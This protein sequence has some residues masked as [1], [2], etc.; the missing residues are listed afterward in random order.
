MEKRFT[1][2]LIIVFGFISIS[3][4]SQT[5]RN[6][7]TFSELSSAVTLASSSVVDTINFLGNITATAGITINKNIFI[8]GN[9]FS[10]SAPLPG[11]SA[12]GAL[13]NTSINYRLF[14]VSGPIDLRI[15]GLTMIGGYF[16]NQ[17]AVM[18]IPSG[19]RVRIKNSKITQSRASAGGG[20]HNQGN[21]AMENCLFHRNAA[22]YGGGLLNTGNGTVAYL[23][24]VSMVE[25][26][27]L[28]SSGGGGAAENGWGSK[29]YF[30][31]STLA[32]NQSTEIGGAINNPGGT[33]YFVNSTATGN[34]AFGPWIASGGAFGNN[35]GQIFLINSLMAYNYSRNGGTA[36]N[37][38]S[39]V[40]DDFKPYSGSGGIRS[41]YSIY[42][43]PLPSGLGLNLNN[44]KY[45]G[46]DDG[47][48]NSIFSGG[49][50]S[51]ITNDQGYEIGVPIFRPFL[52]ETNGAIVS[53]LKFGS[54]ALEAMNRGTRT[55][56][57]LPDGST[58]EVSCNGFDASKFTRNGSATIQ[59][60]V[61]TLTLARS[62]QS[63][64]VWQNDKLDLDAD[65][66]IDADVYLGTIDASGADG[67]AFVLQ[68][69]SVNAGSS[70]GGLG[71]AGISPSIA[72]EYDTWQNAAD[73]T[74]QDH[75]ALMLNGNTGNHNQIPSAPLVALGNI[76]DGKWHKVKISWVAATKKFTHYFDDRLI[77][78]ITYDI[79]ANVFSNNRYV[80][81]GFTGATGGAVNEQRVR[82]N[83]MCLVTESTGFN[84]IIAYYDGYN[85]T[86]L[87]GT[88]S[89]GQEVLNDQ[90]G[91]NRPD[92]PARGA[93]EGIIAGLVSIK[94]VNEPANAGSPPGGTFRG[95]SIY[96]D[97]YPLGTKVSLVASPNTS[98]FQ[99]AKW[100][101]L[102]G[103]PES[104]SLSARTSFSTATDT[105]KVN[106]FEITL[107]QNTIVYPSFEDCGCGCNPTD[108]GQIGSNQIMD[109]NTQSAPLESIESAEILAGETIE[110]K[111][112]YS[113]TSAFEGFID[114]P[115]TDSTNY[116]PG[117]LTENIWFRRLAKN[118]CKSDWDISVSSNVIEIVVNKVF[119]LTISCL[120]NA[121]IP[122]GDDCEAVIKSDFVTNPVFTGQ[123]IYMDATT[124][125]SSLPFGSIDTVG[126]FFGEGV[127]MYGLYS[128]TPDSKGMHQL[129]C[130]GT[131]TSTDVDVPTLVGDTINVLDDPNTVVNESIFQ[132][133]G[134]VREMDFLTWR[135][136]LGFDDAYFRPGLYSCWQS[137][138]HAG[139]DF[140]WPNNGVRTYETIRIKPAFNGYLTL[141]G[142]SKLNSNEFAN[143]AN[144]DPVISVYADDFDPENPCQNMIAF[145][146]SGFIPNPLAGLGFTMGG[147]NG[148]LSGAQQSLSNVFAPWLLHNNPV[149]RMDVK[150]QEGKEYVVVMTHR[151]FTNEEFAQEGIPFNGS[152]FALYMND[153]TT[154]VDTS[155]CLPVRVNNFDDIISLQTSIK[156]NP[157]VINFDSIRNFAFPDLDITDFITPL[158]GG[159]LGTIQVNWAKLGSDPAVSLPDGSTLFELCFTTLKNGES[160]VYLSNSPLSYL[161]IDDSFDEKPFRNDPALITVGSGL[162]ETDRRVTNGL[163]EV[164]FM[165]NDYSDGGSITG[166][167][168]NILSN[169]KDS[170]LYDTS[171][172]F[173][174]FLCF[175]LNQIYIPTGR[176]RYD[177]TY[178]GGTMSTLDRF[179]GGDGNV[180]YEPEDVGKLATKWRLLGQGLLGKSGRDTSFVDVNNLYFG[181]G[182]KEAAREFARSI[183]LDYG[184][185]PL[186]I[187]NCNGF[188]VRIIDDYEQYGD[189]GIDQG[190]FAAQ[191]DGLNVYGMITRTYIIQ[192]YSFRGNTDTAQIQMI[193]R[194]PNLGDL[195]LPHYTV[196]LE[197]DQ[198]GE[199]VH[200]LPNG[201]PSPASTGYPFIPTLTG[202]VDLT[203]DN[204]VCNLSAGYRDV[205][206][207]TDCSGNVSFRREWTIYDWCRPG[208]TVIYNQLIKVGDYTAPELDVTSASIQTSYSG[209]NCIGQAIISRGNATDLCGFHK[210]DL[211]VYWIRDGF[212]ANQPIIIDSVI[213]EE[214]VNLNGNEQI[215]YAAQNLSSSNATNNG[216]F[217]SPTTNSGVSASVDAK[218]SLTVSNLKDGD[219]VAV[220]IAKDV[221]GN[222]FA[223]LDS[224]QISDNIAPT[225]I[226]D[227]IRT[228]TLTNFE[229]GGPSASVSQRGEAYL[230]AE[231]LN[232]G[233][234]DNC[235]EV[236]LEVR[237]M[238]SVGMSVWSDKVGFTCED[239]GDSVLV[240]MKSTAGN[241][242]TICW[243]R[244]SVVDK[245][246][247]KCRDIGTINLMCSD[248][249]SGDL[250]STSLIWDA[251]FR[252][253]ITTNKVSLNQLCNVDFDSNIF[254]ESNIDQCGYGWVNRYYRVFRNIDGKEFA[255]TCRMSIVFSEDHDYWVT[256][257][258]DETSVCSSLNEEKVKFHE[259]GC[260]LI[261]ISKHDEKFEA[262]ANECYKIFRTFRVI[263]WCE[264]DGA[265]FAYKV[266]RRDWNNDGKAGDATTL[267]VKYR[268]GVRH[269]FWDFQDNVLAGDVVNRADRRDTIERVGQQ[270]AEGET[271]Y[272]ESAAPLN[273]SSITSALIANGTVKNVRLYNGSTPLNLHALNGVN[274]TPQGFFEYTQHLQ[275]YDNVAPEI[276]LITT[277]LIF[278]SYSND[279]SKGCPGF[280][281]ISAAITDDCTVSLGDLVLSD[282]LLDSGNDGV[283]SITYINDKF[284][285]SSY[286]GT[287]LYQ[288]TFVSGI[289]NIT[290]QGL[291]TGHHKFKLV[292]TDGCGNK[293]ELDIHFEVKDVKGPAPVCIEGFAVELM[294][295]SS[296]SAGVATVNAVD[297]LVNNPIDDCN[298]DSGVYLITRIRNDNGSNKTPGQILSTPSSQTSI[299]LSCDDRALNQPIQVAVIATDGVG[300][301]D[302]C[303]TTI[304]VQDNVTPCA[305]GAAVSGLVTT[306]GFA[307]IPDV[308]VSVSLSGHV[309]EMGLKMT[310]NDGNYK[311]GGL[312]EGMD[313]SISSTKSDV[314][315]NG[316]STFDIILITKHLLGEQLLNSPYKLI[317]ADVNNSKSI[318]TLDIIHLRKILLG[319]DSQFPNNKVWRFI[320]ADFVFPNPSNPWQTIFPELLNINNL[321]GE[322]R[323][324][325]I[326]IKTGDV[327]GS[328]ILDVQPR[329]STLFVIHANEAIVK[330]GQEVEVQFDANMIG[331]DGFQ[332]TLD[333]GKF[334]LKDIKDGMIRKDQFGLKFIN[335]GKLL[336]SFD[337]GKLSSG[338]NNLFTLVLSASTPLVVSEQLKVNGQFL[339]GEAYDS[340]GQVNLVDLRF[341][342]IEPLVSGFHL[343]QNMPN[344]FSEQT[345]VRFNLPESGN[346][347]ITFN[348]VTGRVLKVVKGDFSKGLN[349]IN[350]QRT[351]LPSGGVYYYT[352][353]YNGLSVTQKMV[354][355]G[356]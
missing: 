271:V 287:T 305:A 189:C 234:S 45:N 101:Y 136:D 272:W 278:E 171:F 264:Y 68:P 295:T 71:Y 191:T 66:S 187:D 317:A 167:A 176:V 150:V 169:L 122:L 355:I 62:N 208:T 59:G 307:S 223:H 279:K 193:F 312:I 39:Y 128:N 37:P 149:T 215:V 18:Y 241:E 258:G 318:S 53:P 253:S 32:N 17:G 255:D 111:W 29:L 252:D 227:D 231:R 164:Y 80:Y 315:V 174:D 121:V 297:F 291:P 4:H 89:P 183:V 347:T 261:T 356:K 127:W 239:L 254:T 64:S 14:T 222:T 233:S 60:N 288:T 277:D 353:R 163:F 314:A 200:L 188:S 3:L 327:N 61:V 146:E 267:N 152:G 306:E 19:A 210:I 220:W 316:I 15:D 145:G 100:T 141:I 102:E 348:D 116:S 185:M 88:S 82:F 249:P 214:I 123:F 268:Q 1:K 280:V 140:T 339:K 137:T 340:E 321:A 16:N 52:Y 308:Q 204:A 6:V 25:N 323:A 332:M 256:F 36:E 349:Q 263:N 228:I 131:F 161:V 209:E 262:T 329:S 311:V 344:P 173:F 294:P 79:K 28:G 67:I 246:I 34:V 65:F 282:V 84:P 206:E 225:C 70:G 107:L 302:Y 94:V 12:S 168:T 292:V 298:N 76:E 75:T 51:K 245:T 181:R 139:S 103:G 95:G 40:L 194:T 219:Y 165:R 38:T 2:A 235:H 138:N 126:K 41:Y 242:S 201:L 273:R 330:A 286:Q 178:T 230:T 224:F 343:Y 26:R 175:D 310:D 211:K 276:E 251:Y 63:G 236:T 192:D 170:L 341:N 120:S 130:W 203:P 157:L 109:E 293:N 105:V 184:F 46:L 259:G 244:I 324:D 87:S 22:N 119:P 158:E 198:L 48:D 260:D 56:V 313:Y 237:R 216:S 13:N 284:D 342:H 74:P 257:P 57:S 213:V 325:F 30:N 217:V 27:S 274:Y 110:Y 250:S 114:I 290:S 54:F 179:L 91:N 148:T 160:Q 338:D 72:I 43:A 301:K 81:W 303:V 186:A 142:A 156:F 104:S 98:T 20:I 21:L 319:T 97:V 8:K 78:D 49:A 135:G 275:V 133:Y 69:L 354:L 243:T 238:T 124:I 35:G 55:R 143:Q 90:A 232:E 180:V 50:L 334:E 248:L 159:P 7:S 320:P 93:M 197:C 226:M 337:K 129:I 132:Q 266:E 240:E 326:G 207:V 134:T 270:S 77:F 31:N 24:K 190:G 86:N 112:Q 265:E 11:I 296:G 144:F 113:V 350:I 352:L 269:I 117:I 328:A 229:V 166:N 118:A 99:F 83:Q 153:I 151:E 155:F 23:D 5:V 147:Q 205:A 322:V 177:D 304:S 44:I 125:P 351:D 106:P 346:A 10:Y 196:T 195:R 333:L 108:G 73:P 33:V 162:D 115:D 335:E 96:G 345:A 199:E 289:L 309:D 172:S 247:P 283:G 42:H 47:T 218:G 336:I 299:T 182:S 85:Y 212:G 300:N 92:P 281:S 9:G 202:F 285:A 58:S 154:K 331:Y 221:C